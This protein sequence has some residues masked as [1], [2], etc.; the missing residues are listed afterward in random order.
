M[1]DKWT[2]CWRCF[3]PLEIPKPAR[4]EWTSACPLC[5]RNKLEELEYAE[6]VR[7]IKEGSS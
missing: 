1:I 4:Y 2:R 6:A 7:R 5:Q 3:A